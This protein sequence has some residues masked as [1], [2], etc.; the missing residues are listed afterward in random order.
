MNSDTLALAA[1]IV[2][3]AFVAIV[4]WL[5]GGRKWAFRVLL[6]VL[7]LFVVSAVGV[8]LYYLWDEHS[9]KV[10]NQKLHECAVAKVA[11]RKCIPA[12]E[13]SEFKGSLICPLYQLPD[14]PTPQQEE[15]AIAAAEKECVEEESKGKSLHD[16]ISHYREL[17]GIKP[18]V[19][20]FA[21]IAKPIDYS[22]I[23][24]NSGAMKTTLS[25]TMCAAKVRK[26]Y[27]DA[28]K[29][30]DDAM[31][32]KKV[33]AKYPTYCDVPNDNPGWEPVIEGPLH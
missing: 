21:A 4:A 1:V 24:K 9:A 15:D 5:G 22:A 8:V 18:P 28:Y 32:I 12:P 10:R 11:S 2:F 25:V 6:S 31:L 33:L 23:A 17:R 3:L 19:D 16:E 29:D 13:G 7:I 30:L 14:N 27:P 26:K 20:P